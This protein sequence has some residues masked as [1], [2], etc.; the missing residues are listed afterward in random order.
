MLYTDSR[1]NNKLSVPNEIAL[2]QKEYSWR[3]D[4]QVNGWLFVATIIS[5]AT[6]IMFPHVVREWSLAWR[7]VIALAP[8]L[9]ISLW[10]RSL[11]RWIRSMDELHRRITWMWLG[12]SRRFF[13]DPAGGI[14]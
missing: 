10:V 12:C 2:G 1:M 14:S 7:A 6:D 3:R 11:T 4:L 8:F 5:A 9:A 13:P